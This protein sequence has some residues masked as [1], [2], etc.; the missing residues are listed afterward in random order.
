M[1]KAFSRP[2]RWWGCGA[3]VVLAAATAC[4]PA[5]VKQ[6][7]SGPGVTEGVP[8]S[9]PAGPPPGMGAPPPAAPPPAPE[10]MPPAPTAPPAPAP[11]PTPPPP[12]SA[13][14][15]DGGAVPDAAA[16]PPAPPTPPTSP[17]DAAP[18]PDAPPTGPVGAASIDDLEDCD[19]AILPNDGRSGNWYQYLD[20]FGSTLVPA[21]FA[22]AMGGSPVSPRCA[23]HVSGMTVN[24]PA[25]SQFGFAGVG[26]SFPGNMAVDS[27]EY[28]G[29]TFYAKGTG[30]IRVAVTIPATTDAQFG[31]TCATN[32]GDSFGFVVDLTPDWKQYTVPWTTL[33]QDGWGTAA[34]FEQSQMTGIDFGFS[35]GWT[36]DAFIDDIGYLPRGGGN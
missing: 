24:N 1:N 23:I 14:A 4:S 18:P 21:M 16:P 36:F 11:S 20:T 32:C 13:S 17:P 35:S 12:P 22:A 28:D 25:M 34:T 10:V 27:S 3:I 6:P 26:F 5:Q 29:V 7:G 2:A 19:A 30:Q 8:P 33:A 31:G 15:P 9:P